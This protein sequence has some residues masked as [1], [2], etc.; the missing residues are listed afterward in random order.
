MP[1]FV[2]NSGLL[3]FESSEQ[4]HGGLFSKTRDQ[5]PGTLRKAMGEAGGRPPGNL[6]ENPSMEWIDE[7]LRPP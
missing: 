2:R 7:G 6:H 3:C 5:L 4:G 1:E